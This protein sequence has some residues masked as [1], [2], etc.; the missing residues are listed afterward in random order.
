MSFK[1]F[2]ELLCT[3]IALGLLDISAAVLIVIILTE[4]Q[5]SA[6]CRSNFL[7]IFIASFVVCG[8]YYFLYG[9]DS[10]DSDRAEREKKV[11]ALLG[12]AISFVSTTLPELAKMLCT[13]ANDRTCAVLVAY[14]AIAV[15]L[16][17]V[18]SYY[19][20]VLEY[21]DEMKD[22]KTENLIDNHPKP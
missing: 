7:I 15:I 3:A 9:M 2:R 13:D 20:R 14:L 1:D 10:W 4:W 5:I 6:L 17:A 22:K 21:I 12:T 16:L 8:R 19:R 18:V 11:C